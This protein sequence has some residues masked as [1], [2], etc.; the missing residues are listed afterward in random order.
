MVDWTRRHP[1]YPGGLEGETPTYSGGATGLFFQTYLYAR[2][3]ILKFPLDIPLATP[4]IFQLKTQR[5]EVG[6][7]KIKIIGV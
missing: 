6:K 2:P 7:T 3:K 5:L 4:N 1:P